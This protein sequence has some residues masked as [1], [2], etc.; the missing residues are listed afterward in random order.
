MG[1]L[2]E[3]MKRIDVRSNSVLR[4]IIVVHFVRTPLLPQELIKAT[5]SF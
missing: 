3:Q 2:L 4:M 5:L 1:E